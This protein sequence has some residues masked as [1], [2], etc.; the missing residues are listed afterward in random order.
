MRI[1][2]FRRLVGLLVLVALVMAACEENGDGD[3]SGAEDG[4]GGP[5]AEE[6]ADEDDEAADVTTTTVAPQEFSGS[7]PEALGPITAIDAIGIFEMTHD[8]SGNFAVE[9]L[10]DQGDLVELLANVIGGFDGRA[11]ADLDDIEYRIQVTADGAWTITLTQPTPTSGQNPPASFEGNGPD[12]VGPLESDGAVTVSMTHAGGGNFAVQ[13]VD[14]GGGLVDLLA[15][16]IGEFQGSSTANFRGASWLL[17]E[18]D[19]AWTIEIE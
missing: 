15:N 1:G 10:D 14:G 11:A 9:L 6:V 17:V 2:T 13:V 5:A 3:T 18:A 16:D 12:V 7:G 4:S 19:G 8:G